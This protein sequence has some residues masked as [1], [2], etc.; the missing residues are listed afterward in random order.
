IPGPRG[1]EKSGDVLLSTVVVEQGWKIPERVFPQSE[2]LCFHIGQ[3]PP[4]AFFDRLGSRDLQ[5]LW[6]ACRYGPK[7]AVVDHSYFSRG[8]ARDGILLRGAVA[9]EIQYLAEDRVGRDAGRR[10]ASLVAG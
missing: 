4:K 10:R 1:A 9:F 3:T 6:Q 8:D 2:P 5:G 7:S